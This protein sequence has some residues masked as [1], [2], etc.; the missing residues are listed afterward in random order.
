MADLSTQPPEA[1]IVEHRGGNPISPIYLSTISPIF[2]QG[3]RFARIRSNYVWA[4]EKVG[5]NIYR[6]RGALDCGSRQAAG[7][8]PWPVRRQR[9]PFAP[10]RGGAWKDEGP[11]AL[12]YAP[13]VPRGLGGSVT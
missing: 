10:L 13:G 4:A 3:P 12:T 7:G 9:H 1:I 6:R 8:C 2:R 11:A 5:F